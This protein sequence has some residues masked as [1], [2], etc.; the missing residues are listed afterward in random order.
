MMNKQYID[1]ETGEIIEG[2]LVENVKEGEFVRKYTRP[3]IKYLQEKAT[4][5]L[6]EY[7]KMIAKGYI[8]FKCN[9]SFGKLFKKEFKEICKELNSNEVLL[10][11][12]LIP[13][14][15][16]GSNILYKNTRKKMDMKDIIE[17]N[18]LGYNATYNAM[19]VLRNKLL[20]IKADDKKKFQ[21]ILNPYIY[22]NGRYINKTIFDLFSNYKKRSKS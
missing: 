1:I 7:E 14:A 12:N 22:F 21:Y 5:E 6:T 2:I 9:S 19:R 11:V 13:Y 15:A 18:S 8:P 16:I 4:N 20:I 17:A 10:L 3:S